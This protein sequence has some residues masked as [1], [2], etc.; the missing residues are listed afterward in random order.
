MVLPATTRIL[1]A[2]SAWAIAFGTM[3]SRS[4]FSS[5]AFA[6]F[7]VMVSSPKAGVGGTQHAAGALRG[8][9]RHDGV[10]PLATEQGQISGAQRLLE[11]GQHVHAPDRLGRL[12]GDD[13]MHRRVDG[14]LEV[15]YVAQ[16][17]LGDDLHVDGRIVEG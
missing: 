6:Y 13:A 3:G 16:Y 10:G 15:E 4:F 7:K 9:Q 14:V 2:G 12:N 5:S 8:A 1:R 11:Q 17:R